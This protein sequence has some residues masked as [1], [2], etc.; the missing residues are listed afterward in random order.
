MTCAVVI[1]V[2][3]ANPTVIEIASFKQ[4]LV[5]LKNY[6]IYIITFKELDLSVYSEISLSVQ[7]K[8]KL[9]FFAEDYFTSV[10]GYNRLCLSRSF[11]ECFL[12]YDYML[13]YQL[14]A[15]VFND[16]LSY[17]CSL[18][19]DYIGAPW[20]FLSKEEHKYTKRVRGV[21]NGGF[22]LR[23]ISHCLRV[24]DFPSFLPFVTPKMLLSESVSLKKLAKY[25]FKLLGVGNNLNYFLRNNINEDGIFSLRAQHSWIFC[26]LPPFD[27]ALKFAFEVNP[28]YLYD[29]NNEKLPFG[30]HAFEKYEYNTF[31]QKHIKIPL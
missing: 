18:G 1:P 25:S 28:S 22:S 15:W 2:Y 11:Y 6:D 10:V 16:E 7:K 23:K 8:Y 27:V 29:I 4:C 30:C 24:L 31:W 5:I 19:Y 9:H 17:W 26:Q 14:D 13:I 12:G 20:F 21:G 3:K